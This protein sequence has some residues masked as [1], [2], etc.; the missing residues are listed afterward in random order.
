MRKSAV[1]AAGGYDPSLRARSAQRCEDRLLYFRMARL[2]RFAVVPEYLNDVPPKP[3]EHV[4][5]CASDATVHPNRQ[6]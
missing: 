3:R 5:Q 6:R 2:G 1:F 4:Q